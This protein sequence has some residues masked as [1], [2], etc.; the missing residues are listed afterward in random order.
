MV[1]TLKWVDVWD[2]AK[3]TDV[4]GMK[5][6]IGLAGLMRGGAKN[7]ES[8]MSLASERTG[9]KSRKRQTH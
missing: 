8:S 4:N 1:V 9:W 2:V 7:V 5:G 6:L 3:R